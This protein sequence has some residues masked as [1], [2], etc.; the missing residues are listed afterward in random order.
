MKR[1]LTRMLAL[2]LVLA[3]VAGLVPAAFADEDVRIRDT[4]YSESQGLRAAMSGAVSDTG[5]FGVTGPGA[6]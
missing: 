1:N 4:A 3:F 6:R 5:G 2:V